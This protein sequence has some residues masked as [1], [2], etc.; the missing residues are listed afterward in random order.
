MKL[1]SVSERSFQLHLPILNG[2]RW[3]VNQTFSLQ[4]FFFVNV[5]YKETFRREPQHNWQEAASLGGVY[6]HWGAPV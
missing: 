4:V 2:K 1:V 3:N 5:M 6:L